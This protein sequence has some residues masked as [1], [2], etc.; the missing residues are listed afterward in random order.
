MASGGAER[1]MRSK[2]R[3]RVRYAV[4]GLGHIAQAAILPAFS[5]ARR[6]SE[7]AALVSG[8]PAKRRELS[9]RYGVP[10]ERC[11]DYEHYAEC[12]ESGAVDAVYIAVP[13]QRHRDFSVR[14]AEAGKHVL[15]EKPMAVTEREC[16]DMVEA[17]ERYGV[18]LMVAYRLHFDRANLEA[19]EA[20]R[21]GKLG[22]PRLFDSVFTMQV[23]DGNIR[24]GPPE[25]GGGPLYDIGIY[26]V[27][28]A[29]YLF[30]AEPSEVFGFS[31]TIGDRRFSNTPEMF[32]AILR[33]PVERLAAFTCSFGAADSGWY[34]VGGTKGV[35]RLDPAYEYAAPL[36]LELT[37]D[38]KTTR[39][40]FPK[41]DQ[42][43]AEL[44]YFSDCVLQDRQ[45]EPSGREGLADVRIIRALHE[46][47]STGRPV[48]LPDFERHHRPTLALAEDQPP[49]KM[50]EVV[51]AEAPSEE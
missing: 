10:R 29:R 4:V 8:D 14:A 2:R 1:S 50:P 18:R 31:A 38:D 23:R 5:H 24:L 39:K 34:Q 45:P 48:T 22:E 30:R 7:L 19:I 6:N 33:F 49:V 26:C 27:N 20:V 25:T 9:E 16:E 17:A 35:M 43:A 44:L 41:R 3:R 12:L 36:K 37:I 15:C 51:H 13:N 32:S 21:S 11:Y 42:F 40:S 28:A 47:A 46:S